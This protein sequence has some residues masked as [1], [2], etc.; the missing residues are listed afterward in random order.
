MRFIANGPS[1][2]DALLTARDAG[3]VLFFCG[4]G[5]SQHKAKL[6][7]FVALARA[8]VDELGSAPDSPARQ[9]LGAPPK[10][11]A[12][13]RKAKAGDPP[14]T[15]VPVD[16]V[17]HLLQREFET[18]EVQRAVAKALVAADDC[19]LAPHMHLLDLSRTRLGPPRLVTTN[20]DLL[21]ERA[22]VGREI[23][24]HTPPNLPNPRHPI[25]FQGIVH[26]HGAVTPSHDGARNDDFVLSSAE[27]GEAYL[28]SGWATRYIQAL[29]ERFQIV[30]VGYSADDPP[31]QYL[32]EAM[33]Q[34]PSGVP[35]MY[36]FHKGSTQEAEAQWLH[37]GV[38]PIPYDT[39]DSLWETMGAW[40]QRARD[41]DAWHDRLIKL[42]HAGPAILSPHERGMIAHLARSAE[43]AQYLRNAGAAIPAEWLFVFD[44]KVRYARAWIRNTNEE[45]E[46]I[47]FDSLCLDDDPAPAPVDPNNWG[48]G[49]TPPSDAWDAFALTPEDQRMTGPDGL[50]RLV[51][52][53]SLKLPRVAPRLSY[54][55][56]WIAAVAHQPAA[57]W[58][59]AGVDGLAPSLM[60]HIESDIHFRGERFSAEIRRAWKLLLARTTTVNPDHLLYRI[61][62]EANRDGWSQ[63]LV[64]AAIGLYKPY[65]KVSRPWEEPWTVPPTEVTMS[66]IASVSLEYPRPHRGFTFPP[67]QQAMA[68]RY[69]RQQLEDAIDLE[70]ELKPK[71]YFH[72]EPIQPENGGQPDED[73]FRISGHMATLC[74]LVAAVAGTD[75]VAAR[76][77][78]RNWARRDDAVFTLLGIW[79][80]GQKAL[81]LASE[82]A[83]TFLSLSPSSFWL[84]TYESD[85]LFALRGRWDELA[86]EARN[87]IEERLVQEDLPWFQERRD[88]EEL[89]AQFRLNRLVWL[90]SR[91]VNFVSFDYQTVAAQLRDVI[92]GW[93]ETDAEE[94]L[95]RRQFKVRSVKVDVDAADLDGSDLSGLIDV[96]RE[97]EKATELSDK[98][99]EPFTGVAKRQPVRALRAVSAKRKVG[100]AAL[101][102][103]ATLLNAQREITLSPRLLVHTARL[104]CA[105][106]QSDLHE[107]RHPAADWVRSRGFELQ[108]HNSVIFDNLWVALVSAISDELAGEPNEAAGRDWVDEAINRPIGTL[109]DMLFKDARLPLLV[110]GQ[111]LPGD[112]TKRLEELMALPFPFGNY[113]VTLAAFQFNWLYGRDKKWTIEGLLPYSAETSTTA[114]AFWAGFLWRA[115]APPTPL[116][117][118][119]KPALIAKAADS[120][121]QR[122]YRKVVSGLLLIGWYTGTGRKRRSLVSDAELRA[123]LI[124]ADEKFRRDTLW[125]LEHWVKGDPSLLGPLI[126]PFLRNAW[127][128]QLAIRT[129]AS[130]AA[131]VR[132]AFAVPGALFE[133]VVE[134]VIPRLTS[135]EMATQMGDHDDPHRAAFAADHAL[136][137]LDLLWVV[138]SEDA[139]DWPDAALPWVEELQKVAVV[140]GR[141]ELVDLLRR[142]H[143][144]GWA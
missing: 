116:Y 124:R 93:Q 112:W 73:G 133:Q 70:G 28:A 64:H 4:A 97:V 3:E 17:F 67:P 43:G 130:S 141:I 37:R 12:K 10:T 55:S 120:T 119:L 134:L 18:K 68:T 51:G 42:S 87:A 65:I 103:W 79:A 75:Q 92:P 71:P 102:E 2:P 50:S 144:A 49:R 60:Q 20:F 32:L 54:L 31:V 11:N 125:H 89:L 139:R 94:A 129:P 113:A 135:V 109:A 88:R 90:H 118:Q 24:T 99:R 123:V 27:F 14:A 85:L 62:G 74:N 40:A 9:L 128:K 16:R 26:L 100:D 59:A 110:A 107:L 47:P 8:V 136:A 25:A 104:L 140:S 38:T 84:S 69:F 122:S 53:A 138:L 23:E 83:T 48:S 95:E 80:A 137:L 78:V 142:K 114:S 76:L 105:L 111:S 106:P 21:F 44:P 6:S 115:V 77:E 127:P 131:L 7:G 126:V 30:F 45:A 61:E 108:A 58:W 46:G 22:A 56:Q 52:T 19:D 96:A 34:A 41:V 132:L 66:S 57:V 15:P 143:R 33:N 29:L 81:T 36:A 86:P 82:A 121:L 72:L 63:A 39:Y 117:H 98:R 35:R 13:G 101:G 5:V 1:I 91:G